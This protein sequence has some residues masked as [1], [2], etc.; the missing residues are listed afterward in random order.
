MRWATVTE[1]NSLIPLPAGYAFEQLS[2][3]QNLMIPIAAP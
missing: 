1:L 2:R 3:N